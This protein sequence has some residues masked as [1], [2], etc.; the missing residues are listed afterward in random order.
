LLGVSTSAGNSTIHHTTQNALNILA[1]LGRTDVKVYK[2]SKLPLCTELR[3]APE[4]HGETGLTGAVLKT[5]QKE[6]WI[7]MYS[8]KYITLFRPAKTE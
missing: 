3:T 8:G 6:Q 2:G 4:V 5:S 1:E 7:K